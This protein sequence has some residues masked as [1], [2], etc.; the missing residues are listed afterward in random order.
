MREPF[1]NG[2]P[3]LEQT[4]LGAGVALRAAGEWTVHHAPAL[5]KLVERTER[6]GG[7]GR[8]SLVIDV[9]QVSR[10]DTFGAWLIERLRRTLTRG[11]AAPMI[12]GLSADHASLVEEVK[13]VQAVPEP[14][15][16]PFGPIR[17]VEA[18]GRSVAEV[19]ETLRDLLNMMGSILHALWRVIL[20]PGHFRLTSMIHQLEQVCWRAVP[21]VVLIT[22]LIGC[23]IAQ[24]GIFQFRKFGADVF[25]V[26]MLGVLVLREIG[27][28]LVAIMVAGR[29]G[30][31]YTAELGSMRMRE[32]IDALRTMGFNPTEVLILPRILALLIAMPILAF[33]G[34]MAALYGGG[35]TAWLYGGIQP[36]AFLSRLREAISIN[37]FTVGLVKA[38]FMALIIGIIACVE[39]AAVEGSAESLGK[40]TTASVVKSI[41]F[42]IVVD[43]LFAIFFASIGV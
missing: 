28:L 30:S 42:V 2:N 19:G 29:S 3:T 22:F 32:E 12:A 21:I 18:I 5:E 9:S 43:G 14:A 16:P 11:E 4:A 36:D 25:V 10:L 39:G 20:H 40:H 13:R 38:P 24:Q 7:G 23:I 17:A 6:S 35:L 1:V 41:F 31:A 37:H 15:K 26:D 34:A 27:V 33:L 8:A